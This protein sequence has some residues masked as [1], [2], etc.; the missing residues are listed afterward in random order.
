MDASEISRKDKVYTLL[1][2][3]FLVPAIMGRAWVMAQLWAWFMVPLG[4]VSIGMAHTLGL[5]TLFG[6]YTYHL[7]RTEVKND[8]AKSFWLMVLV[9]F[10]AYFLGIL[11]HSF[12]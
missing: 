6:M 4:V 9:P 7:T 1:H 11:Y 5:S 3:V 12:M 10:I 8:I 2:L